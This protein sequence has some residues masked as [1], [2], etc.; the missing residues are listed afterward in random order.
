MNIKDFHI[1]SKM[2]NVSLDL[3][4]F[5]E[6]DTYIV[7][8]FQ[9]KAEEK[10]VPSE[11]KI[12]WTVPVDNVL[13][14]WTPLGSFTRFIQPN[15]RR[16][17]SESKTA[18]GAPVLSLVNHDGTNACTIAISDPKT[19]T[20]VGA[21]ASEED[22]VFYCNVKFF[23]AYISPIDFYEA[24]IRIDFENLPFTDSVRGVNQWWETAFGYEKADVPSD[25]YLPM[26]SAWYSFHQALDPE[27]LIEECRRS[28]ALGMKTIIIDDGWQ[29]D[30]NN[31][32]YS[33]CGD[34]KLAT[35]KIPSMKALTEEIHKLGMKV[36]LWYSVPF[37]GIYSKAYE[38]FKD[39]ALTSDKN[40]DVLVVDIRYKEVR[41]YLVDTYVNAVRDFDLDGLKLDFID[42]FRLTADS[43][44]VNDRMDIPSVEDAL[45]ALLCEAK[46]ELVK[47]RPDI[48]LEFRQ[49]YMGPT[50]L[51][52]GNMIR[53]RDCPY[54]SMRNRTHIIDLRL[55]SGKTAVHSDMIMWNK[56]APTE[57]AARQLI[58]TLFGVPQVSVR[59]IDMPREH[60]EAIR[61]W[62]DFYTKN[63]DVLHSED[64][65]VKN[66]EMGYSQVVTRKGGSL[67]G[68]N[69]ANV[70]F[71]IERLSDDGA[72]YTLINSSDAPYVCVSAREDMG[73]CSVRIFDCVGRLLKDVSINICAG[74][75]MLD[76][77]VCGFA[78]I[79]A[80]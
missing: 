78:E 75:L 18:V 80:K 59:L 50:V 2:E 63:I 37:V 16:T 60:C 27:E 15:W 70:P 79:S 54:D 21:G 73:D 64:M 12:E 52:Y 14:V 4:I 40:G 77:P 11:V 57:T 72:H 51:K 61:F 65:K 35:G 49:S 41:D 47:L 46:A 13:S 29:T 76:V 43:P 26:D 67:I 30:D 1:S 8:K 58:S 42:R 23:T 7:L 68:V 3:A 22:A 6:S 38:R 25:A 55:T 31:R 20:E 9:M 56:Y 34:W 5:E 10:I 17:K 32:G 28:S 19:P 45:E 48:L 69:Y 62:L 39:M 24:Y 53:V 33:Y 71:D 44:A 36:M 66:P 74:A